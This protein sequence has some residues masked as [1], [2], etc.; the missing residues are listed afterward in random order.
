M[1]FDGIKTLLEQQG[2]ALTQFKAHHTNELEDLRETVRRLEAKANR[3]AVFGGGSSM[4]FDTQTTAGAPGWYDEKGNPLRVYGPGEYISGG[5]DEEKAASITIG[6]MMRA[7]ATGPRNEQEEKALAEGTQTAGGYTVPTPLA[8][9]YIDR[10]RAA[11]VC[12][13]A[14]ARTVPMDSATLQIATLE[15]DPTIGW[16]AENA[17]IATGDPT[18]G[19]RLLTAKSIAGYVSLSRELLAD[20]V[21]VGEILENALV[22]TM[23]R[24][25]DRACLFGSGAA[26]D[27]T[28]FI[29]V[30]GI[31]EVSM[32]AN[33][34][35]WANYGP[36]IDAIYAAQAVNVT[37]FTG[38]VMNPR[39]AASLAKL[40]DTTNQPMLE[41]DMVKKIPKFLTTAVPINETFGTGTALSSIVLGD[42]THMLIGMREGINV[43][44]LDQVSATTGQIIFVVHARADVQ[45]A[46]KEALVRLKAIKQ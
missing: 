24:E 45:F 3:Q 33:G 13:Q 29:N 39:T 44:M 10:L 9:W 42:F 2:E 25:I 28:G 14:G 38:A 41:P 23:A 37:N 17:A 16:R 18:F 40:M 11:S 30:S 21:N 31:T 36:Y 12:V 20:S 46:R 8:N 43:R 34:A 35:Q 6:N 26:N 19:R 32:G 5:W 1:E 4:G 22:E 15:T 27:P 7:M